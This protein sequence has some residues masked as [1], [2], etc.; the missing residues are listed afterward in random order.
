MTRFS[1]GFANNYLIPG[2]FLVIAG[3]IFIMVGR[4]DGFISLTIGIS[5]LFLAIVLFASTSGLE[6]DLE[7]LRYRK[8]G[9]FGPLVIGDWKRL[10]KVTLVRIQIHSETASRPAGGVFPIL[11]ASTKSLTYDVIVFDRMQEST[12]IYNFLKYRD[13]KKVGRLLAESLEVNLNDI[14][15]EKLAKNRSRRR[16]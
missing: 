3:I 6:L 9:K 2:V 14:V 15:A 5:L 1:E 11:S 13:A 16:R 7:S 4:N 8:Y 10:P 12:E